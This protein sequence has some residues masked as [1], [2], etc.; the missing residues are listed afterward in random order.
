MECAIIRCVITVCRGKEC[1]LTCPDDIHPMTAHSVM[2]HALM[3]HLMMTQSMMAHPMTTDLVVTHS[4]C[5]QMMLW[6]FLLTGPDDTPYAGGCFIFDIYFPPTYPTVCPKVGPC[7][8]FL[9]LCMQ[10]HRTSAGKCAIAF[11]CGAPH[12]SHCLFQC[13]CATQSVSKSDR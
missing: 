2:A 3:A 4:L 13:G 10:A 8:I 1:R 9:V 5:L 12:Y 11:P 7:F 6:R